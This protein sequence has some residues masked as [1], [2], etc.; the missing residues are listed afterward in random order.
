MA[1]NKDSKG[2][3]DTISKAIGINKIGIEGIVIQQK[4]LGLSRLQKV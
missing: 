2:A 3:G 1:D 4:E